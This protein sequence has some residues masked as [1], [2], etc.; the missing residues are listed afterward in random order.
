MEQ[1]ANLYS[2]TLASAYT[3]S[4]G[5]IVVASAAGAPTDGTFSLTI[6]DGTG[7]VLLIFRVTAVS[8]TTFTGASEGPDANAPAGA[9]VVGTMLT[10]AAMAQIK[11]D[12]A[13]LVPPPTVSNPFIQAL[14]APV[15]ASFSQKNFNVGSNVVSTQ[16]NLSSPVTAITLIQHDPSGTNNMMALVKAKLAATFTLTIGFTAAFPLGAN[17][18]GGLYLDDGGGGPTIIHWSPMQPGFGGRASVF[19]NF[20]TFVSDL[21]GPVHDPNTGGPLFWMRIKETASARIYSISSDGVNFAQ[22]FTESNTAH[23]T[24]VNYGVGVANRTGGANAADAMVT[25]YSL[26]ETTP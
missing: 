13:A 25:I 10:V 22:V 26:T 19:S 21:F 2:S 8:G 4:A 24:T 9:T 6:L 14:T 3:A 17:G 7:K 18:I 16:S 11:Q 12:A 1:L 5:S 20:V 15:A 23:F